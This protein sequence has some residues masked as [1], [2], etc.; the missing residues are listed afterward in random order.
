MGHGHLVA[1][2]ENHQRLAAANGMS[3]E[4]G[5]GRGLPRLGAIG[6]DEQHH[7]FLDR[8]AMEIGPCLERMGDAVALGLSV[9][10][11]ER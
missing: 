3:H 10:R 8:V 7:G 1:A 4:V 5:N 9:R 2:I 6:V 11:A